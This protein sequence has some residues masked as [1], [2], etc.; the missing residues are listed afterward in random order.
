[1]L[2]LQRF[3]SYLKQF[4]R[5]PQRRSITAMSV[6]TLYDNK[7]FAPSSNSPNGEVNATTRFHYHQSGAHV[8][9]EY[10][11]GSVARGHLIAVCDEQGV[12]DMRYHHVNTTG[13]LMTGKC[14]STPVKLEDGRLRL[15]EKWQW[16]SG[17]LSEGE[18]V[19]EE[20]KQ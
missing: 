17:D 6:P 12:L 20:V 13:E 3:P 5:L 14:K 7:V 8:W 10:S 1:M 9:A 18:S 2:K 11:G 15:L 4:S 19:L 16:T